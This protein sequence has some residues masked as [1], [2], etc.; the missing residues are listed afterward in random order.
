MIVPSLDKTNLLIVIPKWSHTSEV[1]NKNFQKKK[2]SNETYQRGHL[3]SRPI[4]W[5]LRDQGFSDLL[6]LLVES[7][8]S[9]GIYRTFKQCN[10]LLKK[11]ADL[12][13]ET[14][15][16]YLFFFFSLGCERGWGFYRSCALQS[17]V[18]RERGHV[19]FK[20][21]RKKSRGKDWFDIWL[22]AELQV[23]LWSAFFNIDFPKLPLNILTF[24]RGLQRGKKKLKGEYF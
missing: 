2:K 17:R 20:R 11:G 8:I 10:Y 1:Q 13:S 5:K 4:F 12:Y 22:E 7:P 24:L 15:P 6:P 16:S 21:K 9:T 23:Q 19:D 3:S 14:D 18:I